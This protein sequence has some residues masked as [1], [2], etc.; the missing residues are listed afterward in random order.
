MPLH[1]ELAYH[2]YVY[3][4][5]PPDAVAVSVVDWPGVIVGAPGEI[6]AAKGVAVTATWAVACADVTRLSVTL[7]QYVVVDVGE[8]VSVEELPIDVPVHAELGYH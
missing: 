2:L 3:G 8:T 4:E 6:I 1:A 5:V 7:I